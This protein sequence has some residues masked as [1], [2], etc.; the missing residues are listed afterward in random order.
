MN[1][2]VFLQIKSFHTKTAKTS[3]LIVELSLRFSTTFP[4]KWTG[5]VLTFNPLYLNSLIEFF[6][7]HKR[8]LNAS[9]HELFTQQPMLPREAPKLVQFSN[10]E[11]SLKKSNY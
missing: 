5:G 4:D 6:L 3:G 2:C 10:S 8:A 7:S 9:V 11:T 1:N